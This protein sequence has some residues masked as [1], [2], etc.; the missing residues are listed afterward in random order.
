MT[1]AG[2]MGRLLIRLRLICMLALAVL[3]LSPTLDGVVCAAEAPGQHLVRASVVQQ[4]QPA[5]DSDHAICPH[6][7]AHCGAALTAPAQTSVV[8][9]GRPPL[10]RAWGASVRWGS[11]AAERLDRP[12]RA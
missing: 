12:P 6:G 11:L 3:T 1:I 7:H 10:H 2:V 8:E 5:G 4:P 9:P